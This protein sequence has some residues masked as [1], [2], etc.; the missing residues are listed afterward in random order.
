MG[1]GVVRGSWC[2]GSVLLDAGS[3]RCRWC[4][5]SFSTWVGWVV[6]VPAVDPEHDPK[7]AR[8]VSTSSTSSTKSTLADLEQLDPVKLESWQLVDRDGLDP[9][10]DAHAHGTHRVRDRVTR[11]PTSRPLVRLD[12]VDLDLVDFG[13]IGLDRGKGGRLN[14]F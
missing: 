6:D 7:G 12:S 11:H 4:G 8:Y 2:L 1:V 9:R 10:T 3:T 5:S 13:S 14:A